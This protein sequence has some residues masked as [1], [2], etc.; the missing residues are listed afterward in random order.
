M[1]NKRPTITPIKRT[2]ERL[3]ILF[4]LGALAVNFPILSLFNLD[5]LF[6]GIPV[7][8]LYLFLF[9]ILFIALTALAM[10]RETNNED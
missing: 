10:G 6:L 4:G 3:L 2:K 1:P 5:Q 7:L 9:W 8:F